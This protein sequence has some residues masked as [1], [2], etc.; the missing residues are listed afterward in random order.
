MVEHYSL[1]DYNKGFRTLMSFVSTEL[2]SFYMEATKDCLYANAVDGH[3]RRSAQVSA[4][5]MSMSMSISI[6][7]STAAVGLL[8]GLHSFCCLFWMM[9]RVGR[10]RGQLRAP[11]VVV[12]TRLW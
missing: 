12:V 9:R 8:C 6:S 1:F 5:S 10:L 11:M 7:R 3:K 4:F 2:S